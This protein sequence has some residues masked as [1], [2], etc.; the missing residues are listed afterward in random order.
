MG[1]SSG[2]LT[3]RALATLHINSRFL[4]VTLTPCFVSFFD[5]LLVQDFFDTFTCR[6]EIA[7]HALRLSVCALRRVP[8]TLGCLGDC[9]LRRG[10]KMSW[11]VLIFLG[12]G[13]C[14]WRLQRLWL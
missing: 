4:A 12:F 13:L 3:Y 2:P 5:A 10:V 9:C 8:F 1:V 7:L 14:N 11:C 6:L